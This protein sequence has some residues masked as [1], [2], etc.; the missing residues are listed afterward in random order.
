MSS[1][2][3]L[4]TTEPGEALAGLLGVP[5]PDPGDGLPLLWHWL[6]LLERPAQADLGDDGH[7]VRGGVVAPPGPGRR[8][9]WA[10]GRVTQWRPL[11]PG[12]ATRTSWVVDEQ[13]KE[14]RSG[15]FT[16]VTVGHRFE[17][18]G[19]VVVDE[20]Q[21][22]VYRPAA[23]GP[24]P[25]PEAPADPAPRGEVA[26]EL[27]V[28]ATVLFRFSALTYNAHRIHYDRPYATG[29]EGHPGLVVHGPLQA[30]AMAEAARRLAGL[31]AGA[32]RLDYRLVAPMYDGEGLVASADHTVDGTLRTRVATRA[33]RPTAEGTLTPL[34]EGARP[35][36]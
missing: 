21:S 8:R 26:W 16:V 28:D 15:A 30:I 23:G 4:V 14:G 19:A 35:S 12:R 29:V 32:V 9:M 20:E 31:S 7:P 11:L 5:A 25:L 34:G 2:S 24:V 22:L 18:D 27:E 13:D 36:A 1:R 17:Q 33:G 10:G 3:G 6:H